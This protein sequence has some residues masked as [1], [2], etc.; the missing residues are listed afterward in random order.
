MA[1]VLVLAV[2]N[3]GHCD[4]GHSRETSHEKCT[5]GCWSLYLVCKSICYSESDSENDRLVLYNEYFS[6]FGFPLWL[7]YDLG[8]RF[9]SKVIE[10]M[11]SLLGIEKIRTTLYHLQSNGSAERVHQ[12]LQQMIR[13]PDPELHQK[14]LAHLGSMLIAYNATWSLVTGFSPYYLMFGQRPW[15]PIDLLF[16]TRREHNLT[17]TIDEFVETLYRHLRKFVKLAEDSA[18]REA[19]WQKRL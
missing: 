10:V 19:L 6:V 2:S 15:L 11:C 4:R 18:L 14:W 1:R 12:T 16:P 9:T 7:M 17:S 8:T 13:K 3:C 5:S